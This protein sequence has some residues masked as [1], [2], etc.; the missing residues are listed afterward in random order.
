MAFEV[1]GRQKKAIQGH[2][3]LLEEGRK[4]G[5]EFA[6]GWG[7]GRAGVAGCRPKPVLGGWQG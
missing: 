2:L 7:V 3:M 4:N 1:A 6:G 5:N